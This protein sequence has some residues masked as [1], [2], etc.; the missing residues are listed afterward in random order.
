MSTRCNI[1]VGDEMFY[2]HTDGYPGGV[3]VELARYLSGMKVRKGKYD[4]ALHAVVMGLRRGDLGPEYEYEGRNQEPHG[5]IDYLYRVTCDSTGLHL[6]CTDLNGGEYSYDTLEFALTEDG[7]SVNLIP[8]S[9]SG[10][11]LSKSSDPLVDEIIVILNSSP[12][13]YKE[14]LGPHW[15]AF[16]TDRKRDWLINTDK[17]VIYD[18]LASLRYRIEQGKESPNV[19]SYRVR[20]AMKDLKGRN[21]W[22]PRR[23]RSTISTTAP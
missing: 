9:T 17:E 19:S 15:T 7:N 6:L 20:K 18:A 10:R 23:W 1:L 12:T 22:G 2:H 14:I 21:D 11:R 8:V 13:T 16:D 5:D 3:G 4:A